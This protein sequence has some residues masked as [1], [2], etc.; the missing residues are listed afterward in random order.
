M[1]NALLS[2][3]QFTENDK[4]FIIAFLLIFIL[5]I[6]IFAFICLLVAKVFKYQA[7]K[8]D[9]LM[10]DVVLTSTITDDK[11]FIR[12]GM[13][14]SNIQFFKASQIPIL[15]MIL[16]I[17]ITV[18]YSAVIRNWNII[19]LFT[20][21]GTYNE[22]TKSYVGGRGF[23]TIMFLWDF[24][25]IPTGVFFG[26]TIWSDWAP[27]L[28]SPHFEVTA[29]ASYFIMP[30]FFTG[31]IWFLLN[32]QASLARTFRIYKLAKSIYIKKL[33]NVRFDSLTN[34]K[35]QDNCISYDNTSPT[36]NVAT[37]PQSGNQQ[38][39]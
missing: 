20:D 24:N 34:L 19:E 36:Q 22:A 33:D 4:K 29:L 9:Q 1:N 35:F 31:A 38:Q 27:I 10:H 23:S 7:L 30:L 13:K 25:N 17:L 39:K 16:A 26:L 18:I 11:Q 28:S 2:L 15:L 6:A 5:V 8:V 14:K 32:C 37:P 21:F 12:V 3:L